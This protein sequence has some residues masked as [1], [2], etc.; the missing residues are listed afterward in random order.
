MVSAE[1][2]WL[3]AL[4][5]E[6]WATGADWYGA[7][8]ELGSGLARGAVAEGK[9]EGSGYGWVDGKFPAEVGCH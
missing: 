1:E 6:P 5:T 9:K 3:G 4:Y 8:N 7:V 2:S